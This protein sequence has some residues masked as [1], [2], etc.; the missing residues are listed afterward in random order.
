MRIRFL[1]VRGSCP[2]SG[3]NFRKYGGNTT[4]IL[5][6]SEDTS[7][8]IDAGTGITNLEERENFRENVVF[9]FTHYHLDHVLGLPFAFLLYTQ[10]Y[11]RKMYGPDF[12]KF[13]M[14][15]ALDL[16]S[17]PRLLP[18]K[19]SRKML[20]TQILPLKEDFT[21]GGFR[22]LSLYSR[23]HPLDGIILY[24]I[25]SR[26]KSVGIATD[27][28]LGDD[29]EKV[30]EFFRGVDLL[31]HDAQYTPEEYEGKRGYGH[32][33]EIMAAEV[34]KD[35]QAGKLLLFHFDPFHRDHVVDEQEKSAREI[36]PETAAARE[37]MELEI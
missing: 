16:L 23:N 7:L 26:G 32:S 29:R 22:I 6:N 1:G 15:D 24:R 11:R 28:E 37:G 31:V 20:E 34:A 33:T 8:I 5:I 35:S 13:S 30:V 4:A 14:N 3:K 25:E 27:Y 17:N 2:V 18:F 36:F 10:G 21:E 12:G 9:L 19:V